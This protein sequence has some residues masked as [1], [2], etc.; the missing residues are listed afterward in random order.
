V[1]EHLEDLIRAAR[2]RD[3]A[4]DHDRAARVRTRVFLR[5]DID[6]QRDRLFRRGLVV[7]GGAGLLLLALLRAAASAP[8]DTVTSFETRALA[9]R[10]LGDAGSVAD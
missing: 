6:V 1:S 9:S 5:H 8:A 4:W 3:G 10:A 7:A 2:L